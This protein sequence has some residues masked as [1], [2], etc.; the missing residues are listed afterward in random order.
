MII[1]NRIY[2]WYSEYQ[3]EKQRN[4]TWGEVRPFFVLNVQPRYVY[5]LPIVGLEHLKYKKQSIQSMALKIFDYHRAGLSK[6]SYIDVGHG[7]LRIP[8]Q[9]LEEIVEEE[10]N[11]GLGKLG[12]HQLDQL[13][14][15]IAKL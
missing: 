7:I 3:S 12:E 5:Y 1:E 10:H 11:V 4:H 14:D 6:A 15:L 2:H 13:Y 8:T 9:D